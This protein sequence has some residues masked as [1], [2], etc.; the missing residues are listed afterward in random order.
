[1]VSDSSVTARLH[2]GP[3][4]TVLWVVNPTREAKSVSIALAGGAWHSAKDVWAG[5]DTQLEGE[6]F[7][8]TIPDR[9][10]AVLRLGKVRRAA[11]S[12]SVRSAHII[13]SWFDRRLRGQ[14]STGTIVGLVE[15]P[16]GAVV[17]NAEISV[18]QPAT[19]ETRTTRTNGTW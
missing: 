5:L 18:K 2:E 3:G 12:R 16:S 17:P 4:G 15:D 19:G 11:M 10:A 13:L 8:I 14:I 9:D 1:M 7:R 6:N